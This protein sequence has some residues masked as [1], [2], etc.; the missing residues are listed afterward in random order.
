[1]FQYNL[2]ADFDP[3]NQTLLDLN[4]KCIEDEPYPVNETIG[5]LL[6]LMKVPKKYMPIHRC[7]HIQIHYV[8]RIPLIGP[9]RPLWAGYGE[10]EYLPPQRWMHNVEH[11]AI[12]ILYHPCADQ[13]QV[14]DS[15]MFF[16]SLARSS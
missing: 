16:L 7:M 10:Y 14:S 4:S 15:R 8:E 13:A 9:H 3:T 12:I 5:P 11:G 2:E 1:M 6:T